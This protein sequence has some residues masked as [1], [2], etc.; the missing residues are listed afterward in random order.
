MYL[1]DTH[2]IIVPD[3]LWREF[4]RNLYLS[5]IPLLL[6]M[7]SP[8]P[9]CY[10]L[11]LNESSQLLRAGKSNE[12][13]FLMPKGELPEIHFRNMWGGPGT[14]SIEDVVRAWTSLHKDMRVLVRSNDPAV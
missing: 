4:L 2:S 13:T 12:Q 6:S 7:Q 14:D 3:T 11:E 10:S 8:K 9:Q 5:W 1:A